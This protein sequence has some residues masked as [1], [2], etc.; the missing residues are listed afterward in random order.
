MGTVENII[1]SNVV[2]F[3]LD[4]HIG[5]P[6][7]C[8]KLKEEFKS[9]TTN[10]Y[11]FHDIDVC[12]RFLPSIKDKKLFCIIQGKLA[13]TIVPEIVKYTTKAVVYIFCFDM[14][15]LTEWAMDFDC[16]LEGGI[17]DHE[18]DLL[19]G[20]TSCLAAYA[21]VKTQEY[22]FKRDACA[23]W[24]ADLTKNAKRFRAE[25]CTLP[26]KTDPFSDKETPCKQ[27]E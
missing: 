24:A 18:K 3:W 22:S 6:E 10:I 16:I 19:A 20:L 9:N 12:K 17:F 23:E 14:S 11:L 7:N 26:H 8:T 2:L 27:P 21:E 25:Q 1:G 13:K 5:V 4:E 15:Y